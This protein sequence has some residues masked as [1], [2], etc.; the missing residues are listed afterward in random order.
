MLCGCVAAGGTE[1]IVQAEGRMDSTKYQEILEA[2]SSKVSP[3]I[4]VEEN[5]V[6]FSSKT[7]TQSI[8]QNQP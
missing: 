5:K 1:N 2:N 3:D 8:P 6:W 7:M 4:E